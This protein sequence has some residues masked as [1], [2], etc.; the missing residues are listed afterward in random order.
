[1]YLFSCIPFCLFLLYPF[2][3]LAHTSEIKSQAL[4]LALQYN[5]VTELTSLLVVEESILETTHRDN[6][7][8]ESIVSGIPEDSKRDL[9]QGLLGP[10]PPDQG[11]IENEELDSSR[12]KLILSINLILSIFFMF[13]F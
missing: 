13:V 12:F 1:M 6:I 5:F 3:F 9:G 7:T 2:L 4:S 8:A 10:N 11:A